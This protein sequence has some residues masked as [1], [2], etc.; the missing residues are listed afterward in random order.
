[1]QDQE[2]HQDQENGK[3]NINIE[4]QDQDNNRNDVPGFRQKAGPDQKVL[5][6]CLALLHR[7]ER[8]FH[9]AKGDQ[10]TYTGHESGKRQKITNK[11]AR[12]YH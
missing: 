7:R 5:S 10:R 4:G 2:H 6:Y 9:A 3:R 8:A 12:R 11:S 1:V